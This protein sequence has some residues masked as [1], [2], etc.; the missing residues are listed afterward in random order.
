MRARAAYRSARVT[1]EASILC[2]AELAIAG[3]A[4]AW[5]NE[6]DVIEVVVDRADVHRHVGMIGRKFFPALGRGDDPDVLDSLRTPILENL[7]RG[8]RRTARRQHRIE[9]QAYVHSR[10]DAQLAIVFDRLERG[11]VPKKAA[12]P[13]FAG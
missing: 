8:R 7:R 11:F 1:D 10:A 13:D 5:H 6:A 9:D 4:Q 2:R 12:V 3:V